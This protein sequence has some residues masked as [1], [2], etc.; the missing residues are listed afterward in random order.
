[1]RISDWSSDV[2][3]SDLFGTHALALEAHGGR[4]IMRLGALPGGLSG[5]AQDEIVT[6]F[7]IDPRKVAPGTIFVAFEGVRVHGEDFIADAI[8]AGAIAVVAR[9]HPAVKGAVHLTADRPRRLLAHLAS[10]FF[11]TF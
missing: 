8:A 1:M 4:G 5:D 2:C 11:P 7:A 9:P 3:S 10:Q 6:G